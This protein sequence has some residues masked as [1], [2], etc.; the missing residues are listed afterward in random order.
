MWRLLS[1]HEPASRRDHGHDGNSVQDGNGAG[2]TC[3][4]AGTNSPLLGRELADL[5]GKAAALVF[6]SALFQ[7]SPRSRHGTRGA[8]IVAHDGLMH[9]IDVF[10]GV[11]AKAFISNV[12][13]K[14]S[15]HEQSPGCLAW[16]IIRR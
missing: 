2:G 6:T 3:K 14:Q 9:R 16:E 12:H 4:I 10:E 7:T 1:R 11:L 15:F 13:P 8:G 5:H